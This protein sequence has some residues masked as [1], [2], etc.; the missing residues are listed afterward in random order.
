V[1]GWEQGAET[2]ERATSARRD[3]ESVGFEI[4][5]RHVT[6]ELVYIVEVEWLKAK[7][8]GSEEITPY[9]LRV[10]MVFGLKAVPGRLCIGT[11]IR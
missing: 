11:Q 10:T 3:G 4:V 8:G 6:P 1:R 5:V 9:A 7:I 2:M